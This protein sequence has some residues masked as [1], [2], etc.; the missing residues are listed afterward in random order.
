MIRSIIR[1]RIMSRGCDEGTEEVGV[2]GRDRRC[3]LLY[4][5]F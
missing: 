5:F 3:V 4:V 2:V 1:R